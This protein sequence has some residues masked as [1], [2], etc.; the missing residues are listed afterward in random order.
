[1]EFPAIFDYFTALQGAPAAYLVLLTAVLTILSWDW[2]AALAAMAAGYFFTG[3][4]YDTL[5][6]PRLATVK[7]LTGW[8][9]CL[10]LFITGKQ[11]GWGERN[12]GETIPVGPLAMPRRWPRLAMLT[13]LVMLAALGLGSFFPAIPAPHAAASI[14]AYALIGLGLLAFAANADPYP[15]G[16]G[17][18]LAFAGVE[19]IYSSSRSDAALFTLLALATFVIAVVIAYLVQH[20]HQPETN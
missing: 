19:L 15:A 3:L 7:L 12:T 18:L 8:F 17:L 4:L 1:M 11:A 10:I 14:A 20:R 16:I 13:V 2:R 9:V 5:L 6:D